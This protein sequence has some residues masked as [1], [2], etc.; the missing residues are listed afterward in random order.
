MVAKRCE[1]TQGGA[2]QY[3]SHL[4]K[5]EELCELL[6]VA[7]RHHGAQVRTTEDPVSLRKRR[8]PATCWLAP[9]LRCAK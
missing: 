4:V 7:I 3:V 8:T 5:P 9:A 2:F 1:L 6:A